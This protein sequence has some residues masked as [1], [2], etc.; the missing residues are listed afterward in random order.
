MPIRLAV[1][2]LDGT[3]LNSQMQVQ[4]ESADAIRWAVSNGVSVMLA[5]GRHQEA[6]YPYW[7]ELDLDLP[8]ICSNGACLFD[9]SL[10]RPVSH[11]PLT[12]LQ[13]RGVLELIR[14][15]QINCMLYADDFMGYEAVSHHRAQL[16]E[17]ASNLR[18]EVRPRLHPVGDLGAL[19][20]SADHVWKFDTF[21]D[22]LYSLKMFAHDVSE[23]LG[24]ECEWS[25]EFGVDVIQKGNSK[26]ARLAEWISLQGIDREE[27]IAFG[28]HYNDLSMF[29]VAGIAVAMANAVDVVRSSADWVTGSNDKSGISD[30]LRRFVSPVN[31]LSAP[32][33]VQKESKSQVL[34]EGRGA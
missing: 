6:I 22:H 32:T 17:W 1:F 27:V 14:K 5:S 34:G 31:V 15:Y 20:D 30:G 23:T 25:S 16:R 7:K 26:G 18:A 10:D 4:R 19:I 3:L 24:L 13:A 21:S 11:T 28:D 12:K 29:R 33:L 2:D 9:F 8:V